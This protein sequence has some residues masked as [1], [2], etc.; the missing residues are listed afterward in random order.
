MENLNLVLK[1]ALSGRGSSFITKNEIALITSHCSRKE[2]VLVD[3][4]QESRGNQG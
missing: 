4:T 3:W 1:V 2:P